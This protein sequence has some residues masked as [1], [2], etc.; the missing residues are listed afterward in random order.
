MFIISHCLWFGTWEQLRWEVQGLSWGCSLVVCWPAV[1]SE[2]SAGED[3]PSP[4][5]PRLWQDL[6][7]LRILDWG[8]QILVDCWLKV[9]LSF[10]PWGPRHRAAHKMAAAFPPCKWVRE[11]PPDTRHSLSVTSSWLWHTFSLCLTVL[12]KARHEIQPTLKGRDC[13]RVWIPGDGVIDSHLKGRLH[14]CP[15]LHGIYE[16]GRRSYTEPLKKLSTLLWNNLTW[17]L[18]GQNAV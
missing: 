6:C 14:R 11:N 15:R 12:L 2:G 9:A 1:S 13:T 18:L 16:G 7:P 5:P 4:P 8:P 3:P 10:L 17:R